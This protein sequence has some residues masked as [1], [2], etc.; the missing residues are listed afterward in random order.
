[1]GDLL[2][3]AEKTQQHV[4]LPGT[5]IVIQNRPYH[6]KNDKIEDLNR[7]STNIISGTLFS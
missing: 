2:L 7:T 3:D 6:L 4:R 1:M 5:T